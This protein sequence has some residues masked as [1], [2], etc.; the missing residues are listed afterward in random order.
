MVKLKCGATYP[1]YG[2]HLTIMSH[3]DERKS[4]C[5]IKFAKKV[6]STAYEYHTITMSVK[7]LKKSL[8]IKA[9]EQI[10]II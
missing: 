8:G 7:E 4:F 6:T 10:T 1:C 9:N 5:I 2:G 3:L